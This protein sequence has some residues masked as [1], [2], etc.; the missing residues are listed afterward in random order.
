MRAATAVLAERL[1]ESVIGAVS[2]CLSAPDPSVDDC[3]GPGGVSRERVAQ[4]LMAVWLVV[5]LRQDIFGPTPGRSLAAANSRFWGSQIPSPEP[6]GI[7]KVRAALDRHGRTEAEALLPYLLDPFGL[8]TRRALLA[9]VGD[10]NERRARKKAGA[11][12]TPGDVAR[13]LV[14]E[15]IA[16][17]ETTVIDPACG[18]GVFLRAAFS[19][20]C[21]DVGLSAD[22]S[23]EL[24]YGIDIDPRAIDACGIVVAHDWLAR[25]PDDEP[26][27]GGARWRLA[28]LNLAV[29]N[30][31][32]AFSSRTPLETRESPG[33]ADRIAARRRLRQHLA[34]GGLGYPTPATEP[35]HTSVWHRFAERSDSRFGSV[36]MNPPFAPTGEQ[37]KRHPE[38][39]Q[40]YQTLEA[41]GNPAGV[42][43]A[44]P[45]TEVALQAAGDRGCVGI[46]LP[47]S[48]AYRG[49][50]A[51]TSLRRLMGR[52]A[53]WR[54]RFFDR[55]PDGVFGDDVKQRV[56]LATAHKGKPAS[57]ATSHLI[58]WSSTQRAQIFRAGVGA[59]HGRSTSDGSCLPKIGTALE[60][61]VLT[62]LRNQG[63]A[64]G[65]VV[66]RAALTPPSGLPVECSSA[67]AVAPTAYNWIGA[68]RNMELAREGRRATSGKVSLLVF[69]DSRAA[70]AAYAL[71]AS[72]A[73]LWWWRA[74]GD[75]FHVP[76][77]ALTDAPFP[78]QMADQ[79]AV[80]TLAAAGSALWERAQDNP[81][82][83]TNRG[84]VITA[85]TAP[86]VVEEL[87]A[88]D[89]A[90]AD[91]F[92]LPARFAR[93]AR[94]D[95]DR[96]ADA[97]RVRKG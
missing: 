8:T 25:Q 2:R 30:S 78:F 79:D 97:G 22:R 45:F 81:V 41:A 11:F 12:Y 54:L 32:T 1:D 90:V 87:D 58:R 55:V 39:T 19:H 69:E 17:P 16:G 80:D 75:L 82:R 34:Q 66:V 92:E 31:L 52:A 40:A 64:L 70:D 7:Q 73:F 62:Q 14:S 95:A 21:C 53:A 63:K 9:G 5:H 36:L 74:T 35:V 26:G 28:R 59:F 56:C 50:P 89:R 10:L 61:D 65:E 57:I 91:A 15:A 77:R 43:L 49:D 44:W 86:P 20:L 47:L 76:L 94:E 96:L 46:V 23:T 4:S 18:A 37:A 88:V 60:A 51:T 71:I 13:L 33:L 72:R 83:S 42:N 3:G 27:I 68:Y 38:L 29:G 48:V 24:I 85:Y 6:E 93:F 67:M 84:V